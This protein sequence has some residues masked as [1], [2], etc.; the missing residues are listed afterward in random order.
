MKRVTLN[1][2]E[3]TKEEIENLLCNLDELIHSKSLTSEIH[4]D[5]YEILQDSKYFDLSEL[6]HDLPDWELQD[7]ARD[8]VD[9]RDVTYDYLNSLSDGQ[10]NN[11]LSEYNPTYN[12]LRPRSLEDEYRHKLC[13]ALAGKITSSFE[14]EKLLGDDLVRELRYE[15]RL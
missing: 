7:I 1:N 3:F 8:Y 14:L 13:V 9:E 15:I 12:Q 6:I 2:R 4:Y 10:L 5:I 11:L